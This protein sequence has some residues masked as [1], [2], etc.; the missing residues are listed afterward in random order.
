[1]LC[2]LF[3]ARG[4]KRPIKRVVVSFDQADAFETQRNAQERAPL[5]AEAQRT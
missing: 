4:S 5:T 3:P 1:M 2:L